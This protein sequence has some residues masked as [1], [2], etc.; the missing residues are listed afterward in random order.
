MY[1]IANVVNK[2]ITSGKLNVITG[3]K[4]HVTKDHCLKYIWGSGYNDSITK[5]KHKPLRNRFSA[6]K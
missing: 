6:R 3:K 1:N 5:K 2:T 4:I